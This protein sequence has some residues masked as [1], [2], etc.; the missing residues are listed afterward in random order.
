LLDGSRVVQ[1][2]PFNS[3]R[4]C[5]TISGALQVFDHAFTD[6]VAAP[7]RSDDASAVV[8]LA[9]EDLPPGT[10]P[11]DV[12]P[13]RPTALYQL[14]GLRPVEVV[15]VG[16]AAIDAARRDVAVLMAGELVGGMQ[17]VLSATIDYVRERHQF[18]RSIGSF[19]AVKHRLADMYVTVE[20]ARA[21]VQFAA[22][23]CDCGLDSA[24]ADVAAAARWVARSAIDLFD[25]AIHL[26]G[27]IGYSWEVGIHLHLRRALVTREV[28][29]RL[30][31]LS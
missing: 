13:S 4:L 8:L 19:Q 30:D 31:A 10:Q 25:N 26:H 24:A 5:R 3:L 7:A 20:R 9:R 1:F 27:A 2:A 18:G 16:D 6:L 28:L 15:P 14:D 12:D 22:I 29:K 11:R 23:N 21:A 17:A